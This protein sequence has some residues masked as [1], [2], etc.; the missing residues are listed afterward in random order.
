MAQPFGV[1]DF[2]I[3]SSNLSTN[4]QN[5]MAA[6]TGLNCTGGYFD[7]SIQHWREAT[8]FGHETLE[9]K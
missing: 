2:A 5:P 3:L 4:L 7:R 8:F 6:Q 9:N 1:D